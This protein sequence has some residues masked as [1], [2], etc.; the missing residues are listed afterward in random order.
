MKINQTKFKLHY[1]LLLAAMMTAGVA[2]ASQSTAT[3][4]V[5]GHK[6]TAD[7]VVI[8]N[9]APNLGDTLNVTYDYNDIDSDIEATSAISWLYNGTPVVGETASSYTPVLN[10]NTG[11]GN[12]C[13]DFQVLAEVTPQSQTG[14][15][16]IGD[17]KQSPSVSVRLPVIPGFTFP[18]PVPLNWH[19][20][21]AFC[22][23][24]GLSLPTE[25]Q[26]TELLNIYAASGGN[27]V[28]SQQYG[29]PLQG[30]CGGVGSSRIYWSRDPADAGEH[31][32]ADLSLKFTGNV[33]DSNLGSVTCV[34]G[35]G[36][37]QLPTAVTL[38]H[39]SSGSEALN[40]P[41]FANRPVVTIDEISAN[42]SF[43]A[44]TDTD[45]ANYRF[46]W[47]AAGVSTGVIKD[48][49]NTFTPRVQDQGKPIKVVVTLKP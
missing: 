37:A 14:D 10:T 36:P 1:P 20:A 21:D 5:V 2:S 39:P 11:T 49:D 9:P 8:D 42:L 45:L 16:L 43:V 33:L 3:P 29:W 44:N 23:A 26:L 28:M 19:D 7:N 25:A 12:A 4:A 47:F 22:K 46:E 34:A 18:E 15:P 27:L 24:K 31:R 38:T 32:A 41:G 17:A 48:G 6:P 35:P 30:R 40:G 13:S